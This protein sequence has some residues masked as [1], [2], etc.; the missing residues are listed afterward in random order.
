MVRRKTDANGASGGKLFTFVWLSVKPP[1]HLSRFESRRKSGGSFER[2]ADFL[3]RRA[4]GLFIIAF[5]HDA[6]QGLCTR[7]SY[8]EPS[9][10][11][12]LPLH[13]A[14]HGF[15]LRQ[16]EGLAGL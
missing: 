7:R 3:D 12:K 10:R 14:D 5:R 11:A 6:D 4:H 2:R 13:G 15:D 8:D 16:L 1:R 9:A